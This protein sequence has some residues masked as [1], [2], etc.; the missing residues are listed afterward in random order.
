MTEQFAA[1]GEQLEVFCLKKYDIETKNRRIMWFKEA[2]AKREE[3]EKRYQR[4][5]E[6]AKRAA[7]ENAERFKEMMKES[8]ARRQGPNSI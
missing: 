6:E 2:E 4:E 3:D 1:I 8:E 5:K 7:G